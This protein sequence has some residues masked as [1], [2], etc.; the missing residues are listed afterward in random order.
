MSYVEH[1]HTALSVVGELGGAVV[2]QLLVYVVHDVWR[3]TVKDKTFMSS[4]GGFA[5][6]NN[7]RSVRPTPSGSVHHIQL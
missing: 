3:P 7:V 6:K 4:L 5:L 2:E 1:G